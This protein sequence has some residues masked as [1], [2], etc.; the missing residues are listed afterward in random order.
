MLAWLAEY[1]PIPSIWVTFGA[2]YGWAWWYDGRP[3][4]DAWCQGCDEIQPVLSMRF[5]EIGLYRC[6]VCRAPKD[7]RTTL[8]PVKPYIKPHKTEV[9]PGAVSVPN[10]PSPMVKDYL[11][12]G[13]HCYCSTCWARNDHLAFECPQRGDAVVVC[14]NGRIR[15]MQWRD[16]QWGPVEIGSRPD[17]VLLQVGRIVATFH[18]EGDRP[19]LQTLELPP[20]L[21]A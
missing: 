11:R 10:G 5:T 16:T 8:Q 2:A 17:Q 18:A 1:W 20:P 21:R 3:M 9:W 14:A 7:V 19:P 12:K 13:N 6:S 15:E 4:N